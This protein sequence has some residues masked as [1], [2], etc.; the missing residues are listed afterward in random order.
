MIKKLFALMLG[1]MLTIGAVVPMQNVYAATYDWTNGYY[2]FLNNIVADIKKADFTQYALH[3]LNSDGMPELILRNPEI[4]GSYRIYNYKDSKVNFERQLISSSF[5]TDF[6]G[7]PVIAYSD[8]SSETYVYYDQEKS[9]SRSTQFFKS[10]KN[11]QI[12]NNEWEMI[13]FYYGSEVSEEEYNDLIKSEIRQINLV[14]TAISEVGIIDEVLMGTSFPAR[15]EIMYYSGEK[16]DDGANATINLVNNTVE[17]KKNGENLVSGLLLINGV[18]VEEIFPVFI[19]ETTLVPVRA[20]SEGLNARVDWVGALQKINITKGDIFIEMYIDDQSAFVNGER[21]EMSVAPVIINGSTYVP[22]RFVSENLECN[23]Y[24]EGGIGELLPIISVE[25]RISEDFIELDEYDAV[26]KAKYIV[27]N[28]D[29][30]YNN[31]I[32]AHAAIDKNVALK[33]DNRLIVDRFWVINL[34]IRSTQKLLVDK[35]SGH[36][37]SMYQY[38]NRFGISAGVE[39]VI[40][41]MR[42]TY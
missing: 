8:D 33:S 22:I 34:D 42:H 41:A 3:D 40:E 19:D 30:S 37:Y 32:F 29:W 12:S 23:V 7:Q 11:K 18:F 36:V 26:S 35:Y 16:S 15:S 6:G 5:Y 2:D 13:Y 28:I 4:D 9:I 25:D 14:Y 24:Y 1:L 17:S 31:N 20:V 27:K 21:R 10:R 38:G 39:G